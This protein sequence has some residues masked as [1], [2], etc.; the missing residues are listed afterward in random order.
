[1]T[2]PHLTLGEGLMYG[3]IF[4]TFIGAVFF[5]MTLINYNVRPGRKKFY[6]W[7]LPCIAASVVLMFII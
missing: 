4:T 5:I 7:L 3:Y 2:K 1:M 6:G